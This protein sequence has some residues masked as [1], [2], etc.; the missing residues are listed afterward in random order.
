MKEYKSAEY[1]EK[2]AQDQGFSVETGVAG[3]PTAFI[4][5]YGSGKPV[6]AF[7]GDR[8]SVV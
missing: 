6:I 8:K 4:A 2:V 1:L 5:S 3:I 7:L